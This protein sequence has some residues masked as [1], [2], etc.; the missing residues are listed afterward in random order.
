MKTQAVL[1]SGLVEKIHDSWLF[2]FLVLNMGMIIE[3][4]H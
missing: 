3:L 1:D 2:H 4:S